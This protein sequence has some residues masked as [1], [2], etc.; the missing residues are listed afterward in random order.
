MNARILGNFYRCFIE[1]VLTFGFLCWYG[2]LRVANKGI[3][4][5]VVNVSGKVVGVKQ[6]SLDVLYKCR[7]MKKGYVI[8]RDSSHILSQ[9][10]KLLP[11]R[12]RYSM[13]KS[14]T[15]RLRKPFIFKAVECWNEN[16][17]D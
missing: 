15:E 9:Y 13:P 7:V 2:G 11:S 4:N 8:V 5:R 12:R 1:S 17:G 3:L 10:F 14:R 6:K 16:V